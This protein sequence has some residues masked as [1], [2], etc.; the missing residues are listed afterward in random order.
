MAGLLKA[1]TTLS[2]ISGGYPGEDI[3]GTNEEYRNW[4][5][6]P[7]SGVIT[8]GYYFRDSDTRDNANSSRV[9]TYVEDS[10]SYTVDDNN[11]AHV[12][13]THKIQSMARD[14]VRVSSHAGTGRNIKLWN[15]KGGT[16]LFQV[17]NDPIN[18]AH[19]LISTPITVETKT[20]TIAPGGNTSVNDSLYLRGNVPGHDGDVTP[21]IFVDECALGL[22]FLNDLPVDYRP[23]KVWNGTE[24]L[25][26]NR[27][28]GAAN[29]RIENGTASK[30]MRTANGAIDS[31]N[32][33][34]INHPSD[35]M[36]ARYKNMRKVG[37]E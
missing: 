19:S 14:D 27:N 26:H 21:S 34:F 11:V 18:T 7:E 4:K 16:L 22:E 9:I 8:S 29:I 1:R 31:D 32:S 6:I 13:L 36:A 20:F 5:E 12:T 33:P 37:R 2:I 15:K 24:W 3:G 25:S 17:N 23:G 35:V 28:G 30:T 10:Y